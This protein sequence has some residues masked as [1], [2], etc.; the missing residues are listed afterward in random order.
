MAYGKGQVKGQPS[1]PAETRTAPQLLASDTCSPEP[2]FAVLYTYRGEFQ[3]CFLLL[4]LN[5]FF[6]LTSLEKPLFNSEVSTLPPAALFEHRSYM[7]VKVVPS[8]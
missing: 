3:V 4:P 1:Q 8:Q 6:L 7:D 5:V 2:S